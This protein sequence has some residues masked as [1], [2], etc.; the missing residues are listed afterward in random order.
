MYNKRWFKVLAAFA[1][2]ASVA[3]TVGP[4]G[5]DVSASA[6]SNCQAALRQG[7][8]TVLPSGLSDREIC[9]R[10]PQMQGSSSS[11]ASLLAAI[12]NREGFTANPSTWADAGAI[13]PFLAPA[14]ASGASG[15]MTASGGFMASPGIVAPNAPDYTFRVQTHVEGHGQ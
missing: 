9:Y 15:S 7:A 5:A 13:R 11:A 10:L 6:V 2:L 3:F 4:K 1:L 14:F 12:A 8:G